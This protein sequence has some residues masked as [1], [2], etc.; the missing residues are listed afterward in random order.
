VCDVQDLD[1][2]QGIGGELVPFGVMNAYEPMT[3]SLGMRQVET[4]ALPHISPALT[5]APTAK[6]REKIQKH[7]EK[8]M[9]VLER[10]LERERERKRERE[11]QR[12]DIG[13]VARH[14][15]SV[16]HRD[17]QV[18]KEA[19][20]FD[21]RLE[22]LEQTIEQQES[23]RE[24]GTVARAA[25]ASPLERLEHSLEQRLN[26]HPDPQTIDFKELSLVDRLERLEQSLEQR[27]HHQ[28]DPPAIVFKEPNRHATATTHRHAMSSP[29]KL[30]DTASL[31]T[32]AA[33]LMCT[34]FDKVYYTQDAHQDLR[35]QVS[36]PQVHVHSDLKNRVERLEQSL[37]YSAIK[38]DEEPGHRRDEKP[39]DLVYA[40]VT[41]LVHIKA[42]RV[43]N[44]IS[45]RTILLNA[46]THTQGTS[47]T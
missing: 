30:E 34:P 1:L 16:L 13:G 43:S 41:T 29:Q 15:D 18:E 14:R 25:I 46:H 44:T 47:S 22:R 7:A 24:I 12:H 6:R 33:P 37:R 2:Q 32:V 21:D 17:W 35:P 31:D 45:M 42:T 11:L 36:R 27:L 38:P 39:E 5:P 23:D 4:T 20:E 3:P 9:T 10:D 19:R 8:L 28:S 26:Q 40:Q